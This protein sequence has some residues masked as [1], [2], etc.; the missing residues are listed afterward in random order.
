MTE[1]PRTFPAAADPLAEALALLRLEGALYCRSELTAPWGIDLPPIGGCMMFHLVLSGRCWLECGDEAPILLEQ[2]SLALVPHDVG[3]VLLSDP[4]AT[5][6]PLFDIPVERLS[7]RYEILRDGGGGEPVHLICIVVRYDRTAAEH[8]VSLLP[9]VIQV[10]T[11]DQDESGWLQNT[12]RFLS[13][14]ARDLRPGAETLITRLADVLVIQMI[15]AWI[16]SAPEANAGWLA[17]LRDEQVGRALFAIHRE[18]EHPWTV[19]SLARTAGMSRSAFSTKFT[20]LVGETALRYVTVWRMRLA[21]LRLS[22]TADTVAAISARF[23]YESEASFCRAFKRTFG[24][25]PGAVRRAKASEPQGLAV[26]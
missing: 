17:A 1:Q 4:Q 3:H 9:N 23:G 16:D 18:P 19:E 10:H 24:V 25:S 21:R 14:E 11:W 26:A 5:A 15:R 13:R 20:S 6:R 12:M 2:G 7:E 22:E 8:L